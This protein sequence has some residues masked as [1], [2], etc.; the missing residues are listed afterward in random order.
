M[1]ADND[2]G[3]YDIVEAGRGAFDGDQGCRGKELVQKCQ[4]K[5]DSAT[6]RR[7]NG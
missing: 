6:R 1:I 4:V 7:D 5:V 2:G 3:K